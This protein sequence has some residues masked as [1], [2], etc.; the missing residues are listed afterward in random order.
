[1]AHGYHGS[2]NFFPT[3]T[4]CNDNGDIT[5]VGG[6]DYEG[7]VQLCVDGRLGWVCDDDWSVMDAAVACK[8]LGFSE[9]GEKLS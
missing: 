3:A 7:I 4:T 2:G 5:L 1:M 8:Q 9:L 6:S